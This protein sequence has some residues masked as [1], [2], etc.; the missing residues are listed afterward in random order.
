MS[1][2]QLIWNKPIEVQENVKANPYFVYNLENVLGDYEVKHFMGGRLSVKAP[3]E[4]NLQQA[5]KDSFDN[6]KELENNNVPNHQNLAALETVEA[7]ND[8]LPDNIVNLAM[9]SY[10]FDRKTGKIYYRDYNGIK[11]SAKT[12]SLVFFED[13]DG[14]FLGFDRSE[15]SAIVKEFKEITKK[16]PS[17]ITS[18]YRNSKAVTTGKHKG[19]FKQ[20]YFYNKPL[21]Q[22]EKERIIGMIGIKEAYRKIIDLQQKEN[23]DVQ[24]FDNLLVKLNTCYDEFLL[25]F[26]YLNDKVNARLFESDDSYPLIA[27]LEDELPPKE[28]SKQ[29]DYKKAQAF[30][31]PTIRPLSKPTTVNNAIDALNFSLSLGKGVDFSVMTSIYPNST[32][33]SLIE[34]LGNNIMLDIEAYAMFRNVEYVQRND[35]LSGDILTKIDL[36]KEL[37]EEGDTAANWSLYLKELEDVKP[38]TISLADISYK[39]G[40]SWIPDNVFAMFAAATFSDHEFNSVDNFVFDDNIPKLDSPEYNDVFEKS[41]KHIII[42]SQFQRYYMDYGWARVNLALGLE[43]SKKY[44]RGSDIMTYLM[45]NELPTITKIDENDESGKK[46]VTDPV[47]TANLRQVEKRLENL[48]KEF[49]VSRPEVSQLIETTY[50]Q[51]FNRIKLKEYDGSHLEFNGLAKQFNLRGYQKN[52]V[53]R[54]LEDKRALLA[55]EVGAGKTLTMV[56]AA[57]KLKDLGLVKKPMFV[58]PSNLTAQFGQEIL[59]FFPNKKVLVT[60]KKD[61]EKSH[62]KLFV[63]RIMTS[64][65]DGIVI[66]QSQF[67]MIPVSK[68]TEEKFIQRQYN[69]LLSVIAS[70]EKDD[71]YLTVKELERRKNKLKE[72]LDALGKIKRDS[73]IT[74]ENLGVDFLFVDEAHGYK[75]VAPISNLGQIKGINSVTA[76]KNLD[77]QAKINYLHE[78]F[79]NRNVVFATGTPVS[80]SISEMYI[81]MNYIQPDVLAKYGVGNFDDWV[82]AFGLIESSLELNPTGSKYV[83]TKRFSKFVNLPELMSLYKTSTDIMTSDSLDLDIPDSQKVVITSDLT[84]QQKLKLA[85]LVE[86]SEK[87]HTEDVDPTE[88][89]ML[90]ITGEARKL[91]LD[92]RLLDPESSSKDSKKLSQVISNVMDV[93]KRTDDHK[94]TQI[95]FSDQGTPK[96]TDT[97]SVYQDL[98]DR[99]VAAGIPENEIAFMH[100]A[101]D[102]N[103][104]TVLSRKMNAGQ[105]RILIASTEKGGTGLNVQQRMKAVHHLDVPWKPS[106]IIQRNGRLIRQGNMFK[107]VVTYYYITKGSFDNYLWQIQENKLKYITQIMTNKSPIRSMSDIDDEVMTSSDFKAIATSNPFLKTS[108]E[109]NNRIDLLSQQKRNWERSQDAKRRN[110]EIA[111]Q[112]LPKLQANL[113]DIEADLAYVTDSNLQNQDF[114]MTIDGQTYD[115]RANAGMALHRILNSLYIGNRFNVDEKG[116]IEVGNYHDFKI[117]IDDKRPSTQIGKAFL[118]KNVYLVRNFTYTVQVE[119][120]PHNQI[121]SI[122]RIINKINRLERPLKEKQQSIK[123]HEKVIE[124]GFDTNGF[125][126]D[127]ALEYLRQKQFL[128]SPY[129]SSDEKINIA[130]INEK[131]TEFDNDFLASHPNFDLTNDAVVLEKQDNLEEKSRYQTTVNYHDFDAVKFDVDMQVKPEP[132]ESTIKVVTTTTTRTENKKKITQTSVNATAKTTSRTKLDDKSNIE[133]SEQLNLFDLIP[134]EDEKTASVSITIKKTVVTEPEQLSLF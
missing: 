109:L 112:L 50:N 89:N 63:S 48:F 10:G 119:L 60:T 131:L 124:I 74:F 103:A 126:K 35:A 27:S 68:E 120:A 83:S 67:E 41:P 122:Q 20:T 40:S 106:D 51:E 21:S 42:N 100:D 52:A 98:K 1:N 71:K 9:Y 58:V 79:N 99:L 73:F 80:N 28:N 15:T 76:K 56:A 8:G 82:G 33:E 87:L 96:K 111:N 14:N 3:E 125:D 46:R 75:N 130:E 81:M 115:K 132:E 127:E 30:F 107:G 62:R 86:R 13:K 29:V 69:E 104:K 34:E 45:R 5:I 78:K 59:K 43:D 61:F 105:V 90:K 102:E 6:F 121:G 95:I 113:K 91:T 72:R 55:H 22:N 47:A 32:K 85:E 37:E 133:I 36:V 12:A 31:E 129:V 101:K 88:D 57:F 24:A 17:A 11:E 93:Y 108:I 134:Q 38:K 94:G 97:F 25:K 70:A 23:Y 2:T 39:L 53:Q 77:M 18:I 123:T 110:V 54:I 114:E 66:G 118:I 7:A 44:S 16:N 84:E 65:Y 117:K 116:L 19:Q 128:L 92:M 49:V 64:D 26:G 4:Q